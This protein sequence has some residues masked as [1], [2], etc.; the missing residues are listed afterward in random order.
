M[1]LEQCEKEGD[2][3]VF[4]T[5]DVK[6]RNIADF[7]ESF[8]TSLPNRDCLRVMSRSLRL[9]GYLELT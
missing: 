1:R 8:P 7:L 5:T 2:Q 4:Y 9:K 6:F 3:V